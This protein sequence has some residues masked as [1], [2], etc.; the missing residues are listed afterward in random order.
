MIDSLMMRNKVLVFAVGAFA[1]YAGPA[2]SS[3]ELAQATSPSTK[4]SAVKL[5]PPPRS[6]IQL[7]RSFLGVNPPVAVG[8]SRSGGADELPPQRSA[9]PLH[10]RGG[11]QGGGRCA[12]RGGVRGV[13]VVTSAPAVARTVVLPVPVVPSLPVQY[14]VR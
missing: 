4:Q 9:D 5:Q 13:T 14:G 1:V 2:L 6:V 7:L 10:L 12:R 11:G 8:G 3:W